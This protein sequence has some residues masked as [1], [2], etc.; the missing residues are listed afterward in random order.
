LW[1]WLLAVCTLVFVAVMV[2]LAIAL[3]RAPRAGA[4]TA[5]DVSSLWRS[6]PKIARVVWVAVG[7]STLLLLVLLGE[8]V[9]TDRALAQMP[10]ADG[11]HIELTAY[12]WWW[13]ARYDD[14]E[15]SRMFV[16]ANELHVPVGRPVVVSLAGGDVIHSFWVPSL[17]GKTDLIPGRP[18]TIAFRAD[19][20]ASTAA[21]ALNSAATSTRT[22]RSLSSPRLPTSTSAGPRASV[23]PH[24]SRSPTRS[25][26][27]AT[28]FKA[29]LARCAMR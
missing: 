4:D 1:Y 26:A 18:T 6:E 9:F 11:L 12:D 10:L 3:A 27:A 29:A 16:T 17:H 13:D 15:P 21:S 22:W 25:G 24:P 28:C 8:S 2:A 20:R 14:A 23:S 19:A 7:V 5:P